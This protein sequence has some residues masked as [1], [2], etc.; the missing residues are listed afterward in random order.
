M[1]NESRYNRL[2]YFLLLFLAY[3]LRYFFII[4]IFC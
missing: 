3:V 1:I 2:G 4:L